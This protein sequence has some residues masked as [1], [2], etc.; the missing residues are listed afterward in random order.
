MVQGGQAHHLGNSAQ[1]SNTS[2]QLSAQQSAKAGEAF[3]SAF[4]GVMSDIE[5]HKKRV[6]ESETLHSHSPPVKKRWQ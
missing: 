2:P 5:R 3:A 6:K 4:S 1:A